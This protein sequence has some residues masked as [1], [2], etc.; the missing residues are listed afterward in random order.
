MNDLTPRL[1]RVLVVDDEPELLEA[2][3]EALGAQGYEAAGAETGAAALDALTAQ[4]FDLLLT[5]LM[6][7]GMDGIELLK[8]GAALDPN[9][10][11]IVM[12]GQGT[13]PTAV[14]AMK[15]GAFDYLLK[16]FR[17]DAMLPVLRRAME[18]RRL[19]LE[20]IQLRET[21]AIYNLSQ[22]VAFSLDSRLIVEKT[23]DAVAQQ[24]DGDE[25]SL[26]LLTPAGDELYVAAV[27]GEGRDGLLGQRV[28][29][30][31]GV[32]GWVARQSEPLILNGEVHDPRFTP[33]Q[34]RPAIRSA[35]S[36][37]LLSAGQLMGVL[38]VNSLRPRRPFTL[39]Q[40]KALSILTSTAA[41]ALHSAALYE[42]SERLREY[43]AGI[44]ETMAEGLTLED[45]HG[46]ITYA[47]AR[48]LAL[49]GYSHAELIGQPWHTIVARRE[50]IR[51]AERSLQNA[52]GRASSYESVL[53]AK[54]GSEIHVL[55]AATQFE[56]RGQPAGILATYADLTER[57]QSEELLEQTND[58][59]TR[60]EQV[61]H[62]GSFSRD[63]TTNRVVWSAGLYRIFGLEPREFDATYEA[64]LERVHPDDRETVRRAIE[65]AFHEHGV[66]A[67]ESRIVLPDGQVRALDSRAEVVLDD[68][69]RP[70]RLVGIAIDVTARK[71]AEAALG[72]SEERFRSWIENSSDVITVVD[73]R[74]VIRYQSP[75]A[76][77]VLGYGQEEL[78]GQSAFD[79]VHPADQ[80]RVL[81]IFAAN[82]Q[83]P[84]ATA[85]AEYRF[86]HHDGTWRVLEGTGKAFV[87][88]HGEVLGLITSRDIT[89][90]K[91]AQAEIER[92]AKFPGENP[93]PIIRMSL[94]GTILYAN[95][96][97]G[98]LLS[99]WSCAVGGRPTA[100]I[101]QIVA[102]CY[103][104]LTRHEIEV[105]ADGAVYS[106]VFAPI[107]EANYV[108][109]Y[110]R[111]ITKRK[112]AEQAL[113]EANS[114]LN[115]AEHIAHLGSWQFDLATHREAWSDGL[116]D[117]YGLQP[118]EIEPTFEVFLSFVHPD[119]RER[120]RLTIDRGF[121]GDQPFD[122]ECRVVPR[123]G[124]E[125][126]IYA[127]SEM[128]RDASGQLARQIGIALDITE[129][130]QAQAA[131]AQTNFMLSRAE[132]IGQ[133][134][135]WEADLTT[136]RETW[137]DGQYRLF[138]LKPGEIEASYD[139]FVGRVH[140]QDRAQMR[141]ANERSLRAGEWVE[142]ECRLVQPDGSERTIYSKTQI[143]RNA[144]GEPIRKIGIGIDITERKRAEAALAAS[145]A[146]LR[147]LFAAMTDAVLVL[148]GQGRYLRIAPTNPRLLVKPPQDLLG[149]SMRD[150]MPAGVADELLEQIRLV[151][152]TQQLR[153]FEYSLTIDGQPLWFEGVASLY[154][155][156]Q[157]L[158]IAHDVTDRKRRQRELEAVSAVA[159][160][161]RGTA[162]RA[163]IVP[164]VLDTVMRLLETSAATLSLIDEST[165]EMV[166]QQGRGDLAG[167]A[168]RRL[169]SEAG[170]GGQVVRSGQPYITSDT[171]ADPFFVQLYPTS[172]LQAVAC[173]P[174]INQPRVFGVLWAGRVQPFEAEEVAALVAIGDMAGS[175]LQRAG[176]YEQTSRR[177]EQ[178][179]AL[180]AIDM[181]ISASVSLEVTL[182]VVLDQVVAQLKVDAA[183]VF[184]LGAD[185]ITLR[186]AAGQGYRN[187]SEP[188][189]R[190]RLGQEYAGR[191]ALERRVFGV[192]DFN[193]L[194]AGA[195][196]V[197]AFEA[198]GFRAYYGVPLISKGQVTGVLEV[199]RRAPLQPD[200]EWM[201][202]L[203]ALAG[204][205][206]IA[207]ENA[208]LFEGLQRSNLELGLAY[209]ATIEG[210]SRALDL[211]DHETEGHSQRVTELTLALARGLGLRREELV[212]IRR[213]ALLH[214]IGKMGVPDGILLKPGPLTE[215]EWAVM[216]QHPSYAYQLL[217]PIAFLRP[218]LDI[219]Y[220][221]HEKWDGTGYP[222]GLKGNAIPLAARIFAVVDV[223]DAL[224]SDRPYRAGWCAEQIREYIREQSGQ[225]FDPDV[226]AAFWTLNRDDESTAS[227]PEA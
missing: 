151:I 161:L 201:H 168:G 96:I 127:R 212:H 27:R 59:L 116:Y 22:V 48:L 54:D 15:I 1:G 9:L 55:V 109:V 53:V 34:P 208:Q 197:A 106:I 120:V 180:R 135:S 226:V 68:Q 182:N 187:K 194:G 29:L 93:N 119:D 217:E 83:D 210:W 126:I 214:D 92:L 177:L 104:A 95:S 52:P 94:D 148:D 227:P 7:P 102:E 107:G 26:M 186:Y 24:V 173:V 141:L 40:V 19:R 121:E 91:A 49:L 200:A 189:V 4:P 118:Q 198:E 139:A 23:V 193:D 89:E 130:K 117:L 142:Y 44:V 45:P 90:R 128:T 42:E 159:T 175:A 169:P 77:R 220:C 71:Q 223:W 82:I 203:E 88:Q 70:A 171:S 50:H 154:R 123:A 75:S 209:D 73:L 176:L 10:I 144:D 3:V 152:E 158:W 195:I 2:L 183:D 122:Y 97:S 13:V 20:N 207:V 98:P 206:A 216:R 62:I 145:E 140:P 172:P 218:A 166:I 136:R 131:L 63:I 36:M 11:G 191:V 85:Q 114:F 30:Q 112:Q 204:Q 99:L 137:S 225:H 224:R 219:P 81:E 167:L 25:V 143:A 185:H 28:P 202:F 56:H 115:R 80:N 213:G 100:E 199:M 146:E 111:D 60:A 211:R 149:R 163:E 178:L 58:L 51:V 76:Q 188:A 124:G 132:Q 5:D 74:G 37:P 41:S 67:F 72:E 170:I 221:H 160:A 64:Y 181:A 69:G 87:D 190:L 133:I 113:A 108:N 21:V 43:N 38:N 174:L 86:R 47:N 65:A 39:G 192:P 134:G 125:R 46:R 138:G 31:Q 179:T 61:G 164:V 105:N 57:K 35:I 165:G 66:L 156:D 8:A 17:L 162:T 103:A 215:A 155:D 16:P 84:E 32:A 6:M 153:R 196:R 79:Y 157:V 33:V 78:V 14:E 18:V 110:G 101:C 222:R 129:R 205:A 150:V 12:T 147:A 184:T